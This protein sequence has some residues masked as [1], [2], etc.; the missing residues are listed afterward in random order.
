MKMENLFHLY[1]NC[2]NAYWRRSTQWKLFFFF[3]FY[4][5]VDGSTMIVDVRNQHGY[6][7][8]VST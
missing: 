7:L 6:E 5:F 2:M 1:V 8:V 3:S 4:S